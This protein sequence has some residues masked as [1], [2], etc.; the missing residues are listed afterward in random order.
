MSTQ[1][2]VIFDIDSTLLR[3]GNAHAIFSQVY[4]LVA[5]RQLQGRL[6]VAAQPELAIMEQLRAQ[7]APTLQ[8][9]IGDLTRVYHEQLRLAFQTE[10][11]VVLKGARE[12]LEGLVQLG[13]AITFA[14]GNSRSIANLKMQSAGLG[15]TLRELNLS[16]RGGFGDRLVSKTDIVAAA[17]DDWYESSVC[18]RSGVIVGD[19]VQ[20]MI[21]GRELGIGCVGVCTGASSRKALVDAG[22][23][24]VLE[25]L[26]PP[27]RWAAEAILEA[28]RLTH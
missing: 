20:D 10:P 4:S 7:L 27:T 3:V 15:A 5:G 13:G 12:I 21:A 9:S 18:D 1:T 17:L 11:P 2:L 14:T 22:A 8:V 28:A 24:S 19:S 6:D 26:A 25:S 16:F 23:H